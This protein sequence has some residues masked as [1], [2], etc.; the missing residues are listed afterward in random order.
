MKILLVISL[1]FLAS[2]LQTQ[3]YRCGST[4]S[5]A[6]CPGGRSVETAPPVSQ[7]GG[8]GATATLFLCQSYG[9]GK[10]WT[11]EHCSTRSALIDRMET[12]PAD[13]AFDQQVEMARGQRDRGQALAAPPVQ[14][15]QPRPAGPTM[16]QRCEALDKHI[17]YLDQLA[18]AGGS[19]AYMDWVAN[20][21]KQGRDEQ[22]RIRCS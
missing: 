8:G 14:T 4:Y 1:F 5:A 3:V 12:V 2:S 10:F 11:R 6:P 22:F 18:R 17:R 21:R 20:E 16:K 19:A 7:A 13:L 9:G 15:V